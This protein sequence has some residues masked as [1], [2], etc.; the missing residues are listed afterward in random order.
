MNGQ[1][2][3]PTFLNHNDRDLFYSTRNF[4]VLIVC[5]LCFHP[6]M[7]FNFF[8]VLIRLLFFMA[9]MSYEFFFLQN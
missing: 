9:V 4:L 6:Y 7:Y 8:F 3:I 2:L 5:V 1:T